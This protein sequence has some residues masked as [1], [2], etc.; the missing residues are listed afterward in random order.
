M[1]RSRETP[2][3]SLVSSLVALMGCLLLLMSLP[4]WA[5]AATPGRPTVSGQPPAVA[6]SPPKLA[7]PKG[8]DG[9]SHQAS[10]AGVLSAILG[11]RGLGQLDKSW[12]TVDETGVQPSI[13]ID[14][15]PSAAHTATY[16]SFPERFVL[17]LDGALLPKG[18]GASSAGLSW[19]NAERVRYS[20]FDGDTVRVVV[21]LR[22]PVLF[23]VARAAIGPGRD[24]I[25]I[26]P[27][28]S[29]TSFDVSADDGTLGPL[30]GA[31]AV[32]RISGDGALSATLPVGPSNMLTFDVDGAWSDAR[33]GVPGEACG[34]GPVTLLEVS[35]SP[36]R[37]ARVTADLG[38][39]MWW[40]GQPGSDPGQL[41]VYLYPVIDAVSIRAVEGEARLLITPSL[42]GLRAD[43]VSVQEEPSEGNARSL[44]VHIKGVVPPPY[45][46]PSL[47]DS[48]GLVQTI[49]V[50]RTSDG[51]DVLLGLALA[52]KPIVEPSADGLSVR[53]RL[54]RAPLAGKTVIIDPGH[55][56]SDPGAVGATGLQEKSVALDIAQ[57]VAAF[58]ADA[59]AVVLM[60]R[61]EDVYIPLGQRAA[62]G[63]DLAVPADAFVSIH[64]NSFTTPK[65]SGTETWYSK[66]SVAGSEALA[67]CVQTASVKAMG[68]LNRG[69]K[70]DERLAVTR[71]RSIPAILHEIAFLSNAAEESLLS[72]ADARRRVAIALSDGIM[73][74]LKGDG[75]K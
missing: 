23:S 42:V 35:S 61:C 75:V 28:K 22:S 43:G 56:G 12:F 21:D 14:L 13:A 67:R 72:G 2:S 36:D 71:G 15:P 68:L 25:T 49:A 52:V 16:L 18:A 32:I 53:V 37:E 55:G 38:G 69:L 10:L 6:G 33:P 62:L 57:Q 59:G 34:Y 4:Q 26:T 27:A 5:L 74:F 31:A 63:R 1:P 39:L 65:P 3:A 66:S 9:A 60:T 7:V 40:E 29:V 73:A 46:E 30:L 41:L 8:S 20:Q 64:A 70:T 11:K 45:L 19:H 48:T 17:D 58:L 54:T 44:R 50:S 51:S 47:S 24:R